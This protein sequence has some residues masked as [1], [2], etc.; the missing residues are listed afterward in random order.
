MTITRRRAAATLATVL[1]A[2]PAARSSGQPAQ[3]LTPVHIAS[4]PNDDV[5]AALYA[6][7]EGLFRAAGLDVRL[8]AL[9]SGSAIGAAV[10]GGAIDIGRSSLI[11]LITARAHGIPFVLV[12]PS[13]LY[14]ASAATS[15]I[16]VA[17]DSPIRSAKDLDGKIVSV[18]A[19]ND[20][21]G[22]GT[23]FWLDASG[24]DAKTVQYVELPGSAVA[25][26]LS[27][28][29]I[30]AGALA[31]PYMDAAVKGGGIRILAHHLNA[32]A[33]RLLQSAWFT[34]ADYL[35]KNRDVVDRFAAVMAKAS[36]YC[37]GHHAETIDL[38]AGFAKMDPAT[39][40]ATTRQTFATSM[41]PRQIQPLIDA[42]FKYKAIEQAFP[43]S[44]FLIQPKR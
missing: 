12:A 9:N 3:Q 14:L 8:D 25:Q 17:A 28:G 11:P 34:T 37:N 32:I 44:E 27:S 41:D 20:L 36:A 39:I 31:N 18:P 23:R 26:A 21:D 33:P 38:L 22:I 5:T 16:I 19:L 42:A 24:G 30:A 1:L 29:R 10:A 2:F 35:S 13:G 15:G 7:H 4:T 6:L 43:A 40:A